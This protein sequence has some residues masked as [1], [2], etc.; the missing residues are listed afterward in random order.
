[1]LKRPYII[2]T[3]KK[4]IQTTFDLTSE[5]LYTFINDIKI[6]IETRDIRNYQ[7][8]TNGGEWKSHCHLHW[9]IKI[10]FPSINLAV[11]VNP[12]TDKVQLQYEAHRLVLQ[13]SFG[14]LILIFDHHHDTRLH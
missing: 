8:L 3:P 2:V 1:M 10:F 7:L 9:K 14:L 12:L 4:H 11:N 13:F 5:E 6:F